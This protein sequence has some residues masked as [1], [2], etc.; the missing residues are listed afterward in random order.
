MK[1][2]VKVKPNS[3]G[4][5][6]EEVGRHQLLVKVK[7]PAHENKA[8]QE[9]RERLAEYFRIPKSHISIVA[10]LKSKQKIVKIEED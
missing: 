2:S 4:G 5:Q 7:A 8:N 9:L 3:K 10:G 1:I 6:I